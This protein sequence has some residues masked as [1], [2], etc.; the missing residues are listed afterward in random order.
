M[1]IGV[2][3]CEYHH[4]LSFQGY[5]THIVPST[6][7]NYSVVDWAEGAKSGFAEVSRIVESPIL[8]QSRNSVHFSLAKIEIE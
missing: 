7:L 2:F 1:L 6:T 8:V 4:F 5:Q 3:L